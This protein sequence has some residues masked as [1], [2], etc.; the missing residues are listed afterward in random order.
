MI[1]DVCSQPQA[2]A[3]FEL[4]KLGI[5]PD[6]RNQTGW[7]AY[8]TYGRQSQSARPPASPL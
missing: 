5:S 6:S 2:D 7:S 8:S 1:Y 4:D 3:S